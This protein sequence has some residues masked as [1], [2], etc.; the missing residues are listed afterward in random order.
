MLCTLCTLAKARLQ[1]LNFRNVNFL[2][3]CRR[4]KNIKVENN[5]FLIIDRDRFLFFAY[6]SYLTLYQTKVYFIFGIKLRQ[7][8]YI[9]GKDDIFRFKN[10]NF[11]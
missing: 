8:Q 5:I 4:D 2:I 7:C 6:V 3:T 9:I 1:L 11:A 10:I